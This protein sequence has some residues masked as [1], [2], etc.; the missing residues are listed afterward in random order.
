[1]AEHQH[2]YISLVLP[3]FNRA[4]ALRANLGGMLALEGVGEL[5]L[6][7][8]GSSDETLQVCSDFT[9]E[10]LKVISH[11]HNMGVARARNTGIEAASGSWILFGE[12]DCRFPVDYAATLRR[13]AEGHAADI[14]GAPLVY[15]EG[16]EN[17]IEE[18]AAARPRRS[19][20][21]SMEEDNVFLDKA[22]ITPF[23][24]AR[25]LIRAAVFETVKFYEGF[26]SNGYREETDFFVQASRAGFRCLLTPETYCYQVEAWYGGQH[27]SST[28]RYEYWTLRNNWT[29]LSRHG[30]WLAEQGYIR[31]ASSEQLAFVLRRARRVVR[32]ASRARLARLRS[33]MSR[34]DTAIGAVGSSARD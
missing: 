26:P 32:G 2:D 8:D 16:G 22:R 33:R 11:P 25:V 7:D 30:S 21:P 15:A 4:D 12:D 3:T 5:V 34:S 6:V 10:R 19:S 20:P 23:L 24:P 1:M 31:G 14:V 9:D 27:H 17:R 18:Y 29:F 13:E 28:W